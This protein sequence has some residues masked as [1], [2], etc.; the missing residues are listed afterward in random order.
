MSTELSAAQWGN[1]LCRITVSP[2]SASKSDN[3]CNESLISADWH[4]SCEAI[5]CGVN[6]RLGQSARNAQFHFRLDP[7]DGINFTTRAKT[8]AALHRGDVRVKRSIS[9]NPNTRT[10]P[11]ILAL[12]GAM[13]RWATDIV[14]KRR[15]GDNLQQC[16][17]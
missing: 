5:R 13:D 8:E 10:W 2:V 9:V 11:N 1:E 16:G 7:P 12:G 14:R 17:T 4:R 6:K 15:P 3:S